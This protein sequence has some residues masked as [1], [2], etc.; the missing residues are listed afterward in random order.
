M[1]QKSIG[2]RRCFRYGKD[3]NLK[4]IH[5]AKMEE[6]LN[7]TVVSDMAKILI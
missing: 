2:Q 3:T 4:A 6:E 7:G 1:K 5:N